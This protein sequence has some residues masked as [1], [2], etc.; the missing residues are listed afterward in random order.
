[1]LQISK[2]MLCVHFLTVHGKVETETLLDKVA[3]FTGKWDALSMSSPT[4]MG[5]QK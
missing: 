2:W 4:E 5:D 3:S 1:M